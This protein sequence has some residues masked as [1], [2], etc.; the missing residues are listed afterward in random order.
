MTTFTELE[1]A[2][3]SAI[4]AETPEFAS[5][6]KQQLAIATVVDRENTGGGFF[7]TI[8]VDGD[9][10]TVSSPRVLGYETQARVVGMEYGLGFVLFV[11]EGKL[12][13]LEGF[14]WGGEDTARLR[15]Y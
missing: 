4:F 1:L 2:A 5:A 12:A 8:A 13:L 3:L 15:T 9:A 6:L 14:S 10:P 11:E 7:T